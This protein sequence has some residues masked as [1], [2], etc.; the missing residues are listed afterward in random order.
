MG[1]GG[2][3]KGADA[4]D[5]MDADALRVELEENRQYLVRAL[6]AV[7][8]TTAECKEEAR[9]AAL[10]ADAMQ[11]QVQHLQDTVAERDESIVRL[12]AESAARIDALHQEVREQGKKM[13]DADDA[14]RGLQEALEAQALT[15]R[16]LREQV[17]T[18]QL[19]VLKNDE[20]ADRGIAA[21]V[22]TVDRAVAEIAE[23]RHQVQERDELLEKTE[24][25]AEEKLQDRI[26]NTEALT[27]TAL[28]ETETRILARLVEMGEQARDQQSASS[29][30][31]VGLT[32]LRKEWET[33]VR[34]AKG[35]VE[36]MFKGEMIIQQ[37]LSALESTC[38]AGSAESKQLMATLGVALRSLEDKHAALDKS[39]GDLGQQVGSI[40][41][42]FSQYATTLEKLDREQSSLASDEMSSVTRRIDPLQASVSLLQAGV[43]EQAER[44]QILEKQ[45]GRIAESAGATMSDS[46]LEGLQDAKAAGAAATK[47]LLATQKPD[48]E[49][50]EVRLKAL[51]NAG[52]GTSTMQAAEEAG[53]DLRLLTVAMEMEKRAREALQ[54]ELKA[55]SESVMQQELVL[56]PL[57]ATM[58]KEKEARE[59]LQTRVD[60][61][62]QAISAKAQRPTKTDVDVGKRPHD[63]GQQHQDMKP[64]LG[65]VD[66]AVSAADATEGAAVFVAGVQKTWT[67]IAVVRE[68]AI[69]VIIDTET[70]PEVRTET[71]LPEET[72]KHVDLTDLRHGLNELRQEHTNL[73]ERV[74][75][76][77]RDQKAAPGMQPTQGISLETDS[78]LDGRV[79]RIELAMIDILEKTQVGLGL[80]VEQEESKG[81]TQRLEQTEVAASHVLTCI[82]QLSETV[83]QILTKQGLL[84]ERLLGDEAG[85]HT[86]DGG[87]RSDGA[88]M[89]MS[90]EEV[91]N[92][93]KQKTMEVLEK[94]AEWNRELKESFTPRDYTPIEESMRRSAAGV[95]SD[96]QLSAFRPVSSES[97]PNTLEMSKRADIPQLRTEL[98]E[99]ELALKQQ[100]N[101]LIREQDLL[102][103]QIGKYDQGP[104]G[105]EQLAI[106]MTVLEQSVDSLNRK[107]PA[108]MLERPQSQDMNKSISSEV[109]EEHRVAIGQANR[110]IVEQQ[111]AIEQLSKAQEGWADKLDKALA[112]AK[113]A[114]GE[115][116]N[117]VENARFEQIEDELQTLRGTIA[118]LQAATAATVAALDD[119]MSKGGAM[120]GVASASSGGMVETKVES[121]PHRIWQDE[122]LVSRV[123]VVEQRLESLSNMSPL[124]EHADLASLTEKIQ[125]QDI[126]RQAFEA[127][128]FA[129][130]KAGTDIAVQASAEAGADLTFLTVAMEHER[131]AREALQTRVE[132]L[133]PVRDEVIAGKMKTKMELEGIKEALKS[134]LDETTRKL[135]VEMLR[136]KS[137]KPA[138]VEN[139]EP[140]VNS[141]EYGCAAVATM[142]TLKTDVEDDENVRS[143]VSPMEHINQHLSTLQKQVKELQASRGRVED[144]EMDE[145]LAGMRSQ[146]MTLHESQTSLRNQV[147]ALQASQGR[148]ADKEMD[149]AM[150]ALQNQ[151]IDLHQLQAA[152][153]KQ[154][155]GLQASQG[156]TEKKE[157]DESKMALENQLAALSKSQGALE[158]QIRGLQAS[159]GR[160]EDKEMDEALAG[161]R[162]Q[163]MTLHESQTSL[164]NQVRALQAS[165]GRE[166]DKEMDEAMTALQNQIM[167]LHALFNGSVQAGLMAKQH[168]E[169]ILALNSEMEGLRGPVAQHEAWRTAWSA[170]LK[171]LGEEVQRI[172]VSTSVEGD[173]HKGLSDVEE[174][175]AH[176]EAGLKSISSSVAA[177]SSKLA[178]LMKQSHESAIGRL[179][180]QITEMDGAMEVRETQHAVLDSRV[181]K[182]EQDVSKLED[183]TRDLDQYVSKNVVTKDDFVK[184]EAMIDNFVKVE[185]MIDK[186]RDRYLATTTEISQLAAKVADLQ[187]RDRQRREMT[188]DGSVTARS[189]RSLFSEKEGSFSEFHDELAI[190]SEGSAR[191]RAL[192]ARVRGVTQ[193][194]ISVTASPA[195]AARGA[196]A[197]A[198]IK[199]TPDRVLSPPTTSPR[200]MLEETAE[201]IR[202]WEM[203]NKSTSQDHS[204]DDHQ[205]HFV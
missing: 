126:A 170:D 130:E 185:A 17:Y 54:S 115:K 92:I 84:E 123:G 69:P 48:W 98:A 39:Y 100:L 104:Q 139:D 189:N 91:H 158:Q 132:M 44:I 159:Q 202:E 35:E 145:A 152:F 121:A 190:A 14:A 181:E 96:E 151:V 113:E 142:A 43:Q 38:K 155:E 72:R 172:K 52:V 157:T 74:M 87:I 67:E 137:S 136:L 40:T 169:L 50:P 150:T 79:S 117:S 193:G 18:L 21:M 133:E 13:D 107:S 120:K 122:Q 75:G 103:S 143:R 174:S 124:S 64:R 111:V 41:S 166:A 110:R 163:V 112:V 164:R 200:N 95:F 46:A 201:R 9:L 12:Q 4:M 56:R 197:A 205:L 47:P 31:E 94:V 131:R 161:M 57:V 102:R 138:T 165:Q 73:Y 128:V 58:K 153:A 204:E 61:G 188:Q 78:A 22:T 65:K 2:G 148:E 55:L 19:R 20:D 10:K 149:E 192:A 53:V 125:N 93:V 156:M 77:E 108:Y 144:K 76:I 129:L 11:S 88:V 42:S 51:D 203:R 83:A 30:L 187:D 141:V 160:E 135:G 105:N 99:M 198:G 33:S 25:A 167:A 114:D 97:P 23:L 60:G 26:S 8:L 182:L 29:S 162:S 178:D 70:S 5:V 62:V 179:A 82:Q 34:E 3:E 116:S 24:L 32:E 28:E 118:E 85:I 134:E 186:T 90:A 147:R 101:T 191:I 66:D 180:A 176:C 183:Q 81:M 195:S 16:D 106:R 15:I 80:E 63:P 7:E 37:R 59:L 175:V 177:L 45:T 119:A 86:G 127:R 89:G 109:N 6:R 68:N 168:E 71:L 173:L 194:G 146:V 184:V 199:S 140:S 49:T 36:A 154:M 196:G 1:L 171:A 27:A